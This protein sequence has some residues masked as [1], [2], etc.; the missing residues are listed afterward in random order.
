V[1][2]APANGQREGLLRD[3]RRRILEA[4][5]A[6]RRRVARDLHDGA[7]QKF[8]TTVINLQLAQATL[9]T[10]PQRAKRYLDAALVQAETGLGELRELVTGIHPPILGHL[11]LNAAVGALADALPIPV[12][13]AVTDERFARVLEDNVYFFV[14][15]ALTNVIKHARASQAAV[16]I[17]AGSM[18]LSAEVRDDGLGGVTLINGGTGLMGLLDRVEALDGQLT[19]ASPP[20]GG[21]MLRAVIPLMEAD[22]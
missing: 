10:D 6:A 12:E 19:I 3:V 21:T 15:E 22:D 20:A 17:T 4:G 1:L 7:Q 9:A 5:D 11:G 18:L 2:S 8:V 16:R 14:S 13:L